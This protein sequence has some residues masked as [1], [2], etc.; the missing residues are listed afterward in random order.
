M[1]V[2]H[3][4]YILCS[5]PYT[6]PEHPIAQLQLDGGALVCCGAAMLGQ[7]FLAQTTSLQEEVLA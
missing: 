4:C 1:Y 2:I 3:V 7:S 6:L 5:V